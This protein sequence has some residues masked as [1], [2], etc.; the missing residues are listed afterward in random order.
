MSLKY[1]FNTP[2][3]VHK[4][5]LDTTKYIVKKQKVWDIYVVYT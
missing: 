1:N 2:S 3:Y 4:T 5:F